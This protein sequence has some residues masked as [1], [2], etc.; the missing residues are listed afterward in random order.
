M[1]LR[2]VPA[3]YMRGGTSKGVFFHARELPRSTRERDALLLRVIGSPDP[4]G[5]HTDGLGGATSSTSKVVLISPS[6][7]D[8]CDVD[9]L[10]G[11]G[12]IGQPLIDCTGNC[13]NRAAEVGPFAQRG[14]HRPRRGDRRGVEVT[15]RERCRRSERCDAAVGSHQEPAV[16]TRRVEHRQRPWPR[17]HELG[18]V[19]VA[20]AQ[21]ELSQRTRFRG[22]ASGFIRRHHPEPGQVRVGAHPIPGR[23]VD[24]EHV[25]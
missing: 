20:P 10:F 4:Y 18:P 24:A 23:R 9:F 8:D 6:K 5:K 22:R 7:R 25:D 1:N 3:V 12:S 17:R 21:D 11:A 19:V 13:G 2:R 14:Q 16:P 15:A